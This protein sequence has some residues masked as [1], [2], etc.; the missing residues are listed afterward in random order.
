MKFLF[1]TLATLVTL[2]AN[3]QAKI[4]VVTG[5]AV[6]ANSS[7]VGKTQATING[8]LEHILTDLRGMSVYTFDLDSKNVSNCRQGC[9]KEWPPVHIPPN[10]IVKAPFGAINGNDGAKQLTLRGMPLYYYDDDKK[11][12]DVFGNYPKW[13]E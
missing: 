12:G 11:V 9:L 5:K 1:L 8:K 7:S 10:A 6:A 13:P 2:N 3:A 4:V